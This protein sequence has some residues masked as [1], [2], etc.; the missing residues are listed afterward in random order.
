M[1]ESD[2]DRHRR[3]II[4]DSVMEACLSWPRSWNRLIQR[5]QGYYLAITP[6]VIF[7]TLRALPND[8][9]K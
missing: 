7:D 3:E 4:A 2:L 9:P 5:G 8:E 6:D 1:T